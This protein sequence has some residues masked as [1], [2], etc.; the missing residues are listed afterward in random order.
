MHP[1]LLLAPLLL[2]PMVQQSR[3]R[4]TMGMLRTDIQV[5][6]LC[7]CKP[8]AFDFDNMQQVHC[9]RPAACCLCYYMA[10]QTLLKWC[11]KSEL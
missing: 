8:S 6:E 2:L 7:V 10:C 4:R 1:S 9:L 5:S 11:P 3:V